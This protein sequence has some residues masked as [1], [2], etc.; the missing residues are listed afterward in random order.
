KNLIKLNLKPEFFDQDIQE[1]QVFKFNIP[2]KADY[3]LMMLDS[4]VVSLYPGN[5]KQI[6]FFINNNQSLLSSSVSG[7]ALLFGNLALE[8]GSLEV[9]Y[10]AMLSDNLVSSAT[11]NKEASLV[12][13][14]ISGINGQGVYRISSNVRVDQGPGFYVLLYENQNPQ[15]SIKEFLQATPSA[16]W[17]RFQMNFQ[18]KPGTKTAKIIIL[19]ADRNSNLYSTVVF[20]GIRIQRVLDNQILLRSSAGEQ[21]GP[22]SADE[23]VEFI[24]LSPVSFEGKIKILNP[25]FLFFKET[26]HPDWQLTLI[27]TDGTKSLK[28]H[29][30]GNLYAN[31]WY[32]DQA[33]EYEFKINFKGQETFSKGILLTGVGFLTVAGY[34]ILMK[35][36][37]I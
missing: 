21:A 26:F 9:S 4:S 7:S 33:G 27:N 16:Q 5:L 24:K 10:P 3:D 17:Q 12:E 35:R 8:P 34:W 25:G 29:F 6:R 36:F 2:V 14:P 15:P 18:T 37:K 1:R 23:Q 11:Y 32:I 19:M 13:V 20:D 22:E 31:A 30:L 28:K